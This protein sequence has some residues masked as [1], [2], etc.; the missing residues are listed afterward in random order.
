MTKKRTIRNAA[1]LFALGVS[2]LSAQV[3]DVGLYG[4][5]N[6]YGFNTE[7]SRIG[8]SAC[9]PSASVNALAYLQNA[10]PSV[11]GTNLVGAT[12]GD[13]Q[14]AGATLIERMG[15]TAAKGT[16]VADFIPALQDYVSTELGFAQ[17]TFSWMASAGSLAD[18]SGDGSDL[19][20]APTVS[21]LQNALARNEA[22][23]GMF[24]YTDWIG[25]HAFTI[26]GLE[27]DA[28]AGSGTL[29]FVDPLDSSQTYDGV[30]GTG[31]AKQSTGTL[32][33][34]EQ[35]H[36]RLDY[37]QY[38][39][40]LPYAADYGSVSAYLDVAFVMGVIPEPA[41]G[42]IIFGLCALACVVARGRRR[43]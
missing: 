43:S 26:N 41:S 5:L 6:Q 30:F 35:G 32:S 7:G 20:G 17:T 25:G 28:V 39:G 9:V 37:D 38:W 42:A 18:E 4:W 1:A 21:F 29:Y 34:T 16:L 22:I 27:W 14:D 40:T 15:T 23:I 13:W 31:P 11:F 24:I 36:L 2:A 10:H 12:Y 33:L 3:L 19:T 8:D